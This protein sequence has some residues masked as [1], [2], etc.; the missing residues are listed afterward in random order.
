MKDFTDAGPAR[1]PSPLRDTILAEPETILEDSDLMQAL[2]AASETDRGRNVVDLRGAAMTRLEARLTRLEDTHR[3]V[4]AA[5]YDNL[6]GTAQVHRA[7]L[8]LLEPLTFED[9]LH[10]L[11]TD[12]AEVLRVDAVRL[13]LES[14]DDDPSPADILT[15]VQ[16][17][18]V[19]DYLTLGRATPVRPVVLRS[20][21]H[22]A[23]GLYGDLPARSEALI[24]LD[25]GRGRHPGMLAFGSADPGQF[26]ASQG[27]E[28]LTFL[29]GVFERAMRRWL[30]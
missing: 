19:D 5:A 27:T 16:P 9:F 3:S 21:V 30:G 11:G 12:V 25:F 28:L 24:R 17:G 18:F 1:A 7:I 15:L 26:Q 22:G 8:S 6:T 2:I 14:R 20:L 13:V 10:C 29:G 4:I 23:V